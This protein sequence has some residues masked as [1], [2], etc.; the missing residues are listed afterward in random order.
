MRTFR[1]AAEL[2]VS[3]D[4]ARAQLGVDQLVAL[5]E[6]SYLGG[7]QGALIDAALAAV[8]DD[9]ASL[10]EQAGPDVEVEIAPAPEDEVE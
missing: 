2:A 1:W 7:E 5:G 4:D 3:G 8:V 6:L 10:V 9:T